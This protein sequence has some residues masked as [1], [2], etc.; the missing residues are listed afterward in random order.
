[1]T[2]QQKNVLITDKQTC[3]L[4]LSLLSNRSFAQLKTKTPVPSLAYED[5]AMAIKIFNQFSATLGPFKLTLAKLHYRRMSA[6][7]GVID[8][9]VGILE[10]PKVGEGLRSEMKERLNGLLG[11]MEESCRKVLE[12]GGGGIGGEMALK[13]RDKYA[14][15]RIRLGRMKE[16]EKK[17]RKVNSETQKVEITQKIEENKNSE[18]IKNNENKESKLE[19]KDSEPVKDTLVKKLKPTR[20]SAQID[21]I[22]QKA[23]QEL[24]LSSKLAK[25]SSQFERELDSLKNQPDLICRYMTRYSQK[26]LKN[27]YSKKKIEV[28]TILTLIKAFEETL[29]TNSKEENLTS[30]PVKKQKNESEHD[31]SFERVEKSEETPEISENCGKSAARSEKS[32]NFEKMGR[33]EIFDREDRA[34]TLESLKNF[35]EALFAMKGVSLGLM[36]MVKREKKLLGG[37]V[38]ILMEESDFVGG[39]KIIKKFRLG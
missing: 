31:S 29:Q 39:E 15:V 12:G 36:M 25:T 7:E 13:M 21:N 30:T 2:T 17:K 24:L 5:A 34:R 27:F 6:L 35:V 18:N 32:D 20:N 19:K 8:S 38:K 23:I 10:N 4:L 11:K 9:G 14:E 33:S 22:A 37:L 16:E 28:Q 26:N 1:M 3:S